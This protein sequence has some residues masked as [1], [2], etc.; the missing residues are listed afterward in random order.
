MAGVKRVTMELGS[1]S[2][3]IIMDDADLE[4]AASLVTASGFSNA[5]QVCI[6][7][8]RILTA[9]GVYGDFLDALKPRVE[10][11]RTGDQL[12]DGTKMGPMIRERDAIRVESWVNEAVGAGAKLVTGGKRH[13]TIYEPT[14]LSEVAP[15]QKISCDEL[16]GPAVA[17]TRCHDIDEA[18]RLANST[19]YGL[20]ASI[21]TRDIERAMRFAREVDSG[22]LHVNWGTQWRADLMPYGGLKDSGTGK[23]G[24]HYAI[25]EMTE[26]KMV[27]FHL[28][29]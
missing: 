5:G 2:P 14:V 26:E 29:S 25:R 15:T 10:G 17:V 6:S 8:Q 27:V 20:S 3:V 23:E 19:N 22:N 9:T 18:I 1:N 28:N 16:F 24:P 13:G 11:L 7:A 12:A 21:F 4:L